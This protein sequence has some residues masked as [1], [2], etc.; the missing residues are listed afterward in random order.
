[1]HPPFYFL[2]IASSGYFDSSSTPFSTFLGPGKLIFGLFFQLWAR[3]AQMTPVA[4]KGFRKPKHKGGLSAER[5]R[6]RKI[7][8]SIRKRV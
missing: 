1:M 5:N 6:P 4:G 7:F 3:R 2:W 8:K